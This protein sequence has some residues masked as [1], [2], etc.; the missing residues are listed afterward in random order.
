MGINAVVKAV[1]IGA[2]V[3]SIEQKGSEH[4]DALIPSGFTSNNSGGVPGGISTGSGYICY[5]L[6]EANF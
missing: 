1:E 2:G 4:R 6:F 5:Y 3:A